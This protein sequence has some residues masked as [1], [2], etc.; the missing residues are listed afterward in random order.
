M[1]NHETAIYVLEGEV[2]MWYGDQLEN[3]LVVSSGEFALYSRGVCR[4][5]P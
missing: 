3:H 4:I 5:F 1:K 2:E